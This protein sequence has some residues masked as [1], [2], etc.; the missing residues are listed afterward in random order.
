MDTMAG[1]G[2]ATLEHEVGEGTHGGT[3]QWKVLWSRAPHASE[4]SNPPH[5]LPENFYIRGKEAFI[6]VKPML[7]WISVSAKPDPNWYPHTKFHLKNAVKCKSSIF[8]VPDLR[9]LKQKS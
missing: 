8:C 9:K 4:P 2:A 5:H 1:I 3:I 7:C 6:L